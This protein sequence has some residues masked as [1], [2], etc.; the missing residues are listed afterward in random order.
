MPVT[1]KEKED[2]GILR[3]GTL[4]QLDFRHDCRRQLSTSSL[5]AY[6]NIGSD[7]TCGYNYSHRAL[8]R[9]LS[10]HNFPPPYL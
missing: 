10:C 6:T 1:L 3:R 9:F 4:N 2:K 8:G 7:K 5:P